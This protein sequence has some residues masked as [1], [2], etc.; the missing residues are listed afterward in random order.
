M[1]Y[2][3][4]M[5]CVK[6]LSTFTIEE[7]EINDVISILST[8]K[9]IGPDCISNKMLKLTKFTICKPLRILINKSLAENT[10]SEYW[11]LARYSVIS[12]R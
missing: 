10:F 12:E 3:L 11:K 9:A 6:K 7:Q 8:T 1:F 5:H 2:R 4:C